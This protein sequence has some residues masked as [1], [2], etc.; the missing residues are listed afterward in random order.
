[1]SEGAPHRKRLPG[2]GDSQGR[3][4]EVKH[5]QEEAHVAGGGEGRE[6]MGAEQEDVGFFS[7]GGGSRGGFCAEEGHGLT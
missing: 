3:G 4:P 5:S 7:A 2:S 6:E 1:M